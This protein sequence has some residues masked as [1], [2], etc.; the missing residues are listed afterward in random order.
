LFRGRT[1]NIV[2]VIVITTTKAYFPYRN[3]TLPTLV[4]L[5]LF[6]WLL[7]VLAFRVVIARIIMISYCHRARLFD[8]SHV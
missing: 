1:L 6:V 8:F 2:I 5:R 4:S 3:I 7:L